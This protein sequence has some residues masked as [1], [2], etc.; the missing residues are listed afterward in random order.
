MDL[1][2]LLY[3]HQLALMK[4][5]A[6]AEGADNQS[7][8]DRIAL[9]AEQIR[10]LRDH[11]L[12]PP[13]TLPSGAQSRTLI[14]ATYAGPPNVCSADGELATWESEGGSLPPPADASLTGSGTT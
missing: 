14:Y 10:Q 7:C 1:N 13:E 2:Q 12:V 3:A 11:D 9:I 6:L 5:D 8:A 4:I